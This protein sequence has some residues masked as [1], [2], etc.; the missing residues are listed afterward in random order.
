MGGILKE[1]FGGLHIHSRVVAA[2]SDKNPTCMKMSKTIPFLAAAMIATPSANAAFVIIATDDAAVAADYT[3]TTVSGGTLS[4]LQNFTGGQDGGT[5]T[6]SSNSS[7][8][9]SSTNIRQT[10]S[11]GAGPTILV[12]AGTYKLS[13]YS[14][15][16]VSG[17]TPW[18]DF[19]LFLMSTS[20]T[21]WSGG[22]ITITETDGYTV[23]TTGQWERVEVEYVIPTGHALIGQEFTWGLNGDKPAGG[24]AVGFDSITVEFEAVPEPAPSLLG[25]LGTL[26]LLFRRR[27]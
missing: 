18:T 27:A 23:P 16:P 10:A 12:Q 1:E 22:G 6:R 8:T 9:A 4:A 2:F 15:A 13:A 14:G 3:V 5:F 24:F 11:F 25:S 7:G 17:R 26:L 20:G 21:V 19:D